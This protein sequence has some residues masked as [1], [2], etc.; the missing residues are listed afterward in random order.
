MVK[1]KHIFVFLF[2]RQYEVEIIIEKTYNKVKEISCIKLIVF[3]I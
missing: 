1:M 3:I 2:F